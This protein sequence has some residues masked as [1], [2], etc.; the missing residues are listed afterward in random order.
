[1]STTGWTPE[2]ATGIEAMDRQHMRLFE[3]LEQLY[4]AIKEGRNEAEE[5]TAEVLGA[6]LE[7]ARIH[8]R[9]EEGL[10]RRNFYPALQ[11]HI[12]L[13]GEL[14]RSLAERVEQ[15]KH[16]R[17]VPL[18][19]AI[20]IRDWIIHHMLEEDHKYGEFIR[21]RRRRGASL[22]QPH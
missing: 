10:M 13:H 4:R 8:F 21:A 1:M 12:D 14:V 3:L 16:G 17:V 22:V 18:K 6:L 11:E 15:F 5:Q 20:F 19:L 2:Y 9:N 7:Y